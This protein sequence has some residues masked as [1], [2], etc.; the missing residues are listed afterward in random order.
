MYQNSEQHLLH[1]LQRIELLIRLALARMEQFFQEIGYLSPERIHS[2]LQQPLGMAGWSRRADDPIHPD[3]L[4]LEHQIAT[5][6]RSSLERG[7]PLRLPQLM[8]AF[9]LAPLERD[10]LLLALAPDL[11]P[12]IGQFY[13]YLQDDITQKFPTLDTALNLLCG[14]VEDKIQARLCFGSTQA[15]IKFQMFQGDRA[16]TLSENLRADRR[17]LD[18]LLGSDEIDVRLVSAAS[19]T[20]YAPPFDTLILPDTIKNRLW[21]A[22]QVDDRRALFYLQG[23]YGVGKHTTAAAL[24]AELGIGLVRVDLLPLLAEAD[25]K[26]LLRL[27]RRE[28]LL[29]NAALYFESFDALLQEE[30]EPLLHLFLREIED[31]G[32][33]VFFA[34][35]TAWE[36]ADAFDAHLFTRVEFPLPAYQ[37]RIDLWRWLLRAERVDPQVDLVGLA[38]KF[39]FS[40]GQIRDAIASARSL[41]QSRDGLIRAEDLYAAARLQSNRKLATLARKISPTHGWDDVILPD[42]PKR[43]LWEIYNQMKHRALVLYEWGFDRKLSMGKGISALFAGPSGTG[44]TLAAE[45]IAGALGLELYK[46]DLSTMISKYI[47]ETEKNLS[48]VFKEAETS[49]AILLFD[50]ADAMFGKR[51][52]VSDSHD[53]YANVQVSYLLQRMEEYDGVVILTTNLRKNMDEA[54]VRR[55][56]F[57]IDFPFPNAE[58]RRQ[59]WGKVFPV[60]TPIAS[61][62]DLDHLARKMEIA[63]GNIRNIALGAAYLAAEDGGRVSMAHLLLAAQREYQKMG[64]VIL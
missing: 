59:I 55:M 51:T 54:F 9:D 14:K 6:T 63:G 27:A 53:R 46:I 17:I 37:I 34:G 49:N 20:T 56:Q 31:H 61:D 13:G 32:G 52:D 35:R 62:V 29:Q 30:R 45:I 48:E 47:G 22:L 1:E 7:I 25:F 12:R 41:A 60:E 43:Q 3:L 40:G 36:P 39:R 28:A 18:Y 57:I 58:Y 2:L 24:S 23:E 5:Q 38:T 44:K 15:L 50:E 64:K 11:D 33:I 8:R 42:E 4:R 19:L 26:R 10:V 16:P 21:Q